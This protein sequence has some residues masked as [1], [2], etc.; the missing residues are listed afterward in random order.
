MISSASTSGSDSSHASPARDPIAN[1]AV[2]QASAQI[3]LGPTTV[4]ALEADDD[5][6]EERAAGAS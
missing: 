6:K 1:A 4:T 5:G 3:R 2:A